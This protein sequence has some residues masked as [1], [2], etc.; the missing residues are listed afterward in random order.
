M[1]Q[2]KD[3]Q[4]KLYDE[5]DHQEQYS[6]FVIENAYYNEIVSFFEVIDKKKEARHTFEKDK[7]ILGW[8]DRKEKL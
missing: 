3:N 2:K 8:I 4:I 1:E 6:S 7:A 5:V